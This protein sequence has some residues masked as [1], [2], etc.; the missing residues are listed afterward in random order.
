MTQSRPRVA[1]TVALSKL[2]LHT[3][4]EIDTADTDAAVEDA[5]RRASAI[6][7]APGAITIL[8]LVRGRR[9]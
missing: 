5:A 4:Q 1:L 3:L 8:H 2:L 7:H 9:K 6:L